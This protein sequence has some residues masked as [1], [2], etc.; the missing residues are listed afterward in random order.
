MQRLKC[1]MPIRQR[2]LSISSPP[3]GR[4]DMTLIGNPQGAQQ[5]P[6]EEFAPSSVIGEGAH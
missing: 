4:I 6:A 1:R 2:R 5:L 3:A